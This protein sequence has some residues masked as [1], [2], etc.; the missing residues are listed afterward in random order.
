MNIAS[1][2]VSIIYEGS[3][4]IVLFFALTNVAVELGK[5]TP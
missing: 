5:L 4:R 3:C 2:T 1:Q